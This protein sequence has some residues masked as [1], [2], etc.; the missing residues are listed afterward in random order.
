M[1]SAVTM[2]LKYG[3]NYFVPYFFVTGMTAAWNISW[4][5]GTEKYFIQGK[6]YFKKR[7]AKLT[8]NG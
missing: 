5:I 4:N 8:K 6:K 7:N 2:N 1:I 3:M